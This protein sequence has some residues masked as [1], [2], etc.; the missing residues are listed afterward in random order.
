MLRLDH[1]ELRNSYVKLGWVGG[2]QAST[3]T[4]RSSAGAGAS[5]T[6]SIRNFSLQKLA[7]INQQNLYLNSPRSREGA[8]PEVFTGKLLKAVQFNC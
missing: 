3:E 1:R 5:T 8:E 7:G 4:S 2:L 6:M